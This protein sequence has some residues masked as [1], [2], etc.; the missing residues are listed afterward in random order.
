MAALGFGCSASNSS[1]TLSDSISSPFEWSSSSS[2]SSSDA[3]TAYRQ[4]V[5][6]YTLAFTRT[7]DELDAFR[8][9]LRRLAE[10]RGITNWEA[11]P[12]TCAS[13]GQGLRDADL[14]HADAMSFARQLLGENPASLRAL[15]V[16]YAQVQ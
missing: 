9:G 12:L 7:G 8:D 16:G 10:R 15:R 13:I 4:D 5:S 3:A 2:D 14:G 6:D 1:D 11:D